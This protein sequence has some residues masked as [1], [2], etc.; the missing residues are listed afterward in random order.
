MTARRPAPRGQGAGEAPR[1]HA[2]VEVP[3]GH[4]DGEAPRAW[5]LLRSGAGAPDWNLACDE[6]LLDSD[7]ARPLLRLYAWDPPALSLG[8]FQPREPFEGLARSAGLGLVRRPTGGGAIHHADEL[9]FCLVATPGRDGYPAG[10]EAAYLAVHGLLREALATLGARLEFRGGTAPR[11]VAPRKA[12]LCFDDTTAY[13]LV[14]AAGRKLLGSA[15]RRRDGRVLHHGSLPLSV[16]ALTPG[17]GALGPCLGR[18]IGWDEVADALSRAFAQ[19]FC[20][21]GLQPDAL[22]PGE[23]ARARELVALRAV[24]PPAR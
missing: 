4:G 19:R 22:S 15:Q 1:G 5:R 13:D 14:D 9:T 24:G 20:V 23:L 16:P 2:D 21:G 12:T 7:D 11:S 6:A 3:R 10:I 18:S 17:A 8:W